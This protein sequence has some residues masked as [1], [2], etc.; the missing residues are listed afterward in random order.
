MTRKYYYKIALIILRKWQRTC[1]HEEQNQLVLTS[2]SMKLLLTLVF[3]CNG[4][5]TMKYVRRSWCEVMHSAK[6]G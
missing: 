5:L 1:I 3:L 4:N 2:S 6:V